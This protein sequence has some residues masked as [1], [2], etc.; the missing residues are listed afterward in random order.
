MWGVLTTRPLRSQKKLIWKGE[1]AAS[2]K[3]LFQFCHN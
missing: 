3:K 1:P 2:N